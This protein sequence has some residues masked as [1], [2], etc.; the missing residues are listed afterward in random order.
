MEFEKQDEKENL[1]KKND[2]NEETGVAENE[3]SESAQDASENTEASHH[4]E[5][6]RAMDELTE[7]KDRYLRTVAEMENMR[8]RHEK[9]RSDLL[10]YGSEKIML[11]ILPVLDSFDQ[12]VHGD[13]IQGNSDA[14][15]EGFKMVQKQLVDVLEKHGL[16]AFDSAGQTFDPNHHQAIQRIEAEVDED[17]VRDEFQKGYRLNDRLLRPAMVSVA[18]PGGESNK[19][20]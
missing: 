18:V 11:D 1:S 9:E 4:E 20:S 3:A 6:R 15:L 10:K 5:L 14:L 8:K 2:Q 13:A 7:I 19:D 16:V 12:A 17:V